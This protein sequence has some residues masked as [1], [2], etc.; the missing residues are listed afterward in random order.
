MLEHADAGDLVVTAELGYVAIVLQP[1]FAAILQTEGGDAFFRIG[2]LVVGQRHADRVRAL[3]RRADDQPAPAAAD[4]EQ[5]VAGPQ[6]N[7]AQD[8]VEL[9]ALRLVQR[10]VVAFPVRARVQHVLVE[11]QPVERVGDVVVVLDLLLVAG[12]AVREDAGEQPRLGS[13]EVVLPGRVGQA[14]AD[15]EDVV[16]RA[17]EVDVAFDIGRAEVAERGIEQ[18]ADGRR[19]LQPQQHVGLRTHLDALAGRQLDHQR[20]LPAGLRH[21][22]ALQLRIE[23]RSLP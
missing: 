21:D 6:E 10:L 20:H 3:L 1:D 17:L 2:V 8:V 7:L 5:A 11:E 15:L 22:P 4:V 23:H 16:D 19:R 12:A 14:Y 9:V 18:R 13:G